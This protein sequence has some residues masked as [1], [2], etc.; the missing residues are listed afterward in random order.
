MINMT[1]I[2]KEKLTELIQN[3]EEKVQ[4]VRVI[5]EASSPLK[6][7]YNLAFVHEGEEK[8]DDQIV[9]FDAFDIF[10]DPESVPYIDGATL[11][12]VQT[13]MGAGFR[14]DNAPKLTPKLEG[15]VADKVQKL[16]EEQIN[17]ALAMHGGFVSLIDVKDNI[18]FIELGG[19]CRGCGM[20]DVTLKQ[21]IE[22]LIKQ[23]VPEIT[24]IYDS[25]DHASGK[26]PYYQPAK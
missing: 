11:D 5:A 9:N 16:I 12:Y 10:I 23:N 15:P 20:V 1:D 14:V 6:V 25:T 7:E 26:N 19:G 13:Q 8:P 24:E 22:V 4:G 17:P 3:S 2:A 18:A 21:G